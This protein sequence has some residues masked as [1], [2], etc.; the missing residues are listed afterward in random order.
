MWH[1]SESTAKG[2]VMNPLERRAH[3]LRRLQ[4]DGK[5]GLSE[6]AA[7]LG[8][9]SMTVRRDLRTFVEQGIAVISVGTVYLSEHSVEGLTLAVSTGAQEQ[10]RRKRAIALRAA[11]LIDDGDTII[12]DCGTTTCG[13]LDYLE[14]KRLTIITNS[15]PVAGKVGDNPNVRLVYAPGEYTADSQ[16]MV[17][18]LTADFFRTLRVDK[19][20][21]GAH[22]FDAQGGAHEPVVGD[23]TTKR[24]MLESAER[25][26]L[27]VDSGK[28]GNMH[29]MALSRLSDF[30]C[31]ITDADFPAERRPE[32]EAACN[33]VVYA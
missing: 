28:Y 5:A 24:A 22:G 2:A 17:G 1:D 14:A 8:V 18:P 27:L 19:A 11:Q 31:V 9:S 21:L 6:L 32:L 23:A 15:I 29:F 16:G 25:S 12:V 26:Y 10:S 30:S 3:I 20:F 7:E 33:E 13:M 4:Q